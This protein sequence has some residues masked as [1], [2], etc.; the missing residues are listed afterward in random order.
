MERFRNSR[1]EI[2]KVDRLTLAEDIPRLPSA[3]PFEDQE[4]TSWFTEHVKPHED[5]LRAW[6]SRRFPSGCDIDDVVQEAFI[7]V[8][9]AKKTG[10]LRSPK[11][12]LFAAA[13]NLALDKMKHSSVSRTVYLEQHELCA[14]ED[15]GMD[16]PEIVSRNQE[17]EIMTKA[18]QSIPDRCRQVFTLRKVYGMPQREIAKKLN[19]SKNTVSA[20]LTVGLRKFAQYIKQY[21][22]EGQYGP[23]GS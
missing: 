13:R 23:E 14:F 7:S 6:L 17:L 9:K 15:G 19:I 2:S 11:A 18:I 12:F 1:S 8:L 22:S 21:G 3:M 10:N 4:Q 16:I 20:H 5:V